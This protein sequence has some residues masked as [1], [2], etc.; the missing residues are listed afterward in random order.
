MT[1]TTGKKIATYVVFPLVFMA[2]L[3]SGYRIIDVVLWRVAHGRMSIGAADVVLKDCMTM[4]GPNEKTYIVLS[5][6]D[7]NYMMIDSQDGSTRIRPVIGRFDH[8]WSEEC[9]F[10]KNTLTLNR[11]FHGNSARSRYIVSWKGEISGECTLAGGRMT[12]SA[13]IRA[14]Q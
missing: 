11:L 12:V 2:T 9:D 3:Y 6:D 1:E 7:K 4:T 13:E 10:S 5:D 8:G 14:C